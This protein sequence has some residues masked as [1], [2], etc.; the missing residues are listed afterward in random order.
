MP[1]LHTLRAMRQSYGM[2]VLRGHPD[3][4]I[5]NVNGH[6]MLQLAVWLVVSSGAMT[7]QADLEGTGTG[8]G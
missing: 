8:T 5:V 7:L 1:V 3:S 4:H 6:C 2:F